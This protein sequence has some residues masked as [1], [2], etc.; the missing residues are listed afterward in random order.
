V[1]K[2]EIKHFQL[3]NHFEFKNKENRQVLIYTGVMFLI[4]VAQM[5]VMQIEHRVPI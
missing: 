5:E 3:K 2:V 1:D 4:N